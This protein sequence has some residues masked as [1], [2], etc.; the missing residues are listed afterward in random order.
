MLH[1]SKKFKIIKICPDS[2]A[3][4]NRGS[5]TG[6]ND[7]SEHRHD[8][9]R[10]ETSCTSTST[11]RCSAP[12]IHQSRC[13]TVSSFALSLS[14]S[15][16]CSSNPLFCSFVPFLKRIQ[17]F[18]NAPLSGESNLPTT[19]TGGNNPLPTLPQLPP[20]KRATLNPRHYS[21][22]T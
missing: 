16:F 10:S 18:T 3:T 4:Y 11:R 1:I 7:R 15:P 12:L 17:P 9:G 8:V 6:P 22:S 13:S 5:N 2:D 19:P 21:W 20:S 14:F